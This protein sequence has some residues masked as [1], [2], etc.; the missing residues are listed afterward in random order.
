VETLFGR[1]LL[2]NMNYL[3]N[4]Y[5]NVDLD[6][7]NPGSSLVENTSARRKS[8]SCSSS[9][10]DDKDRSSSSCSFS[11]HGPRELENDSEEIIPRVL[12]DGSDSRS[13][14][15]R[16]LK[17]SDA[18]I[19]LK[20]RNTRVESEQSMKIEESKSENTEQLTVL[21]KT[22]TISGTKQAGKRTLPKQ[23]VFYINGQDV[24]NITL[25]EHELT[26][27]KKQE[28]TGKASSTESEDMIKVESDLELKPL[29]LNHLQGAF[30][31]LLFGYIISNCTILGEKCYAR[32]EKK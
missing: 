18:C 11:I 30:F 3:T 25:S 27:E 19:G 14:L 26:I 15:K 28:D 5:K 20:K 8:R 4:S 16:C 1:S 22:N 24:E 29:T 13:S 32:F 10:K 6:D 31:L 9:L 7:P 23:L 21:Q 17:N 2:S 12:E